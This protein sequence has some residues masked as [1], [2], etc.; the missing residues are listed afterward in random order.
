MKKLLLTT[1]LTLVAVFAMAN[2]VDRTAAMQKAK[3]FMQGINPQAQLQTPATPR[4]TMGDQAQKPYYIFNAEKN[5]GFVIVSGD[6]RSEEILG[7]S[8]EEDL[9]KKIS[10]T[11]HS[12]NFVC[13]FKTNIE[14]ISSELGPTAYLSP[15]VNYLSKENILPA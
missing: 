1:V 6:D 3:N 15:W 9:T 14:A 13:F 8:D 2:P 11:F 12:K 4:K 5:Q 10:C 7:Y